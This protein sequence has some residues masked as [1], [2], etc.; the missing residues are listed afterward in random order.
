M[1]TTDRCSGKTYFQN[2]QF[3][4]SVV[5]KQIDFPKENITYPADLMVM[6]LN[7]QI[8]NFSAQI[9][10]TKFLEGDDI[11]MHVP[12]SKDQESNFFYNVKSYS[13]Y[14]EGSVKLLNKNYN[15]QKK[16]ALGGRDWGRGIWNYN[17]YWIW[18]T[19]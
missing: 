4:F 3:E 13:L 9:N 12:L 14:V 8:N 2:S 19:G 7:S 5:N 17:T 11:V 18:A 10:L 6:S 16:T 1:P 15:I